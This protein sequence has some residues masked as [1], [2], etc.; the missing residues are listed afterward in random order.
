MRLKREKKQMNKI[1]L[2]G[3]L[4]S[5]GLLAGCGSSPDERAA[6]AQAEYTEEKTKTLQEYKECVND[7]D[8]DEQELKSCEALLKAVQAVDGTQ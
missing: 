4:L 3:F 1:I 5:A 7:A 8:G 6:E 2:S